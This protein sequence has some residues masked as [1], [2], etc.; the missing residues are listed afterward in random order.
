MGDIVIKG[1]ADQTALNKIRESQQKQ[2]NELKKWQNDFEEEMRML[3]LQAMQ[4]S[5]RR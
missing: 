1:N 2:I 5:H 3:P 4:W